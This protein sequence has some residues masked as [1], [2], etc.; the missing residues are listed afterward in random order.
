ML[1]LSRQ[2]GESIVIGDED[3][4]VTIHEIH[5]NRVVLSINA[6][7]EVPVHRREVFDAIREQ[8]EGTKE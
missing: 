6:P 3:V 2:R 5:R 1:V 4:E 8:E 7:K